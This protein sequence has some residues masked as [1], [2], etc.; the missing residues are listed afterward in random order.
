MQGQWHRTSAAYGRDA[1]LNEAGAGSAWGF[2]WCEG[3]VSRST[4]EPQDSD[5]VDYARTHLIEPAERE[6]LFA[7]ARRKG[8]TKTVVM[9]E[10]W[11]DDRGRPLIVF[12]ETGPYLLPDRPEP[13]RF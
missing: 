12:Y 9:A 2:L 10:R 3:K 11:E 1:A 7:K 6:R 5:A 8:R 13:D 4:D